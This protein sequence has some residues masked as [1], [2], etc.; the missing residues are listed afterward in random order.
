MR[1]VQEE[2]PWRESDALCDGDE[3]PE[4]ISKELAALRDD[5]TNKTSV[6]TK[7]STRNIIAEDLND[8]MFLEDHVKEVFKTKTPKCELW[9]PQV[10]ETHC[11][12]WAYWD[13]SSHNSI[14]DEHEVDSS[15]GNKKK[16]KVSKKSASSNGSGRLVSRPVTQN[17][18]LFAASLSGRT[19]FGKAVPPA[20]IHQQIMALSALSGRGAG[21]MSAASFT[22]RMSNRSRASSAKSN[23]FSV[24]EIA[25]MTESVKRG[26][27]ANPFFRD[28]RYSHYSAA[29]SRYKSNL[30]FPDERF[31]SR[32][33][34]QANRKFSRGM[35]P[36]GV[37]QEDQTFH[38][39][40]SEAVDKV[41]EDDT[42]AHTDRPCAVHFFRKDNVY[43]KA[44][45]DVHLDMM[46]K[47][48]ADMMFMNRLRKKTRQYAE[49]RKKYDSKDS[50]SNGDTFDN[51]S[52]KS[53]GKVK[54]NMYK[55]D[56]PLP[57][58][59]IG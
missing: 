19:N 49:A 12:P 46:P 8:M 24:A 43:T 59:I 18:K 41:M 36:P 3:V 4:V 45:M 34:Q 2:Y 22:S 44:G 47:I 14:K 37:V 40:Y 9:P 51:S 58:V 20:L 54:G 21:A 7:K 38:F 23:A 50:V 17:R 52:A 5:N 57:V 32:N 33:S 13:D 1:I 29:S 26:S 56:Q 6:S 35:F 28:R 27:Y 55:V 48:Y 10:K 42:A 30:M 16:S 25:R 31:S 39:V 15:S 53:N 11:T